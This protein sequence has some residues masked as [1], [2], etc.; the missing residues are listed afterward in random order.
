MHLFHRQVMV[1]DQLKELASLVIRGDG[2]LTYSS[3]WR[4]SL[5]IGQDPAA[6]GEGGLQDAKD[7]GRPWVDVRGQS[8]ASEESLIVT[9]RQLG[10]TGRCSA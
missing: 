2:V 8:A 5:G 6:L 10:E 9:G 4:P 3:V 1:C 7:D